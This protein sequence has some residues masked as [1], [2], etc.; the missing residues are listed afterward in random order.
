VSLAVAQASTSAINV[1]GIPVVAG[2]FRRLGVYRRAP[3]GEPFSFEPHARG[4]D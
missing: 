4:R 3:F 1:A 2:E